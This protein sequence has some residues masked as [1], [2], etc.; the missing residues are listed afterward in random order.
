MSNLTHLLL[1][2]CIAKS[3]RDKLH[4]FYTNQIHSQRL[5]SCL[6]QR[7]EQHHKMHILTI[8]GTLLPESGSLI[9]EKHSDHDMH[10]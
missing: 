3:G 8:F 9:A 10:V 5:N 1:L 2:Y 6:S 7:N 4:Y